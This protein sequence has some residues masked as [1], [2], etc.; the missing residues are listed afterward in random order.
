MAPDAKALLEKAPAW[1]EA[2]G[3]LGYAPDLIG[4]ASLHG[5]EVELEPAADER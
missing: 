3:R 5:A 2:I 1:R 4:D